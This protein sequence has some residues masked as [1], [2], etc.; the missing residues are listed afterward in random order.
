MFLFEVKRPIWS[1]LEI[2][3]FEPYFLQPVLGGHLAILRGW[4]L[5]TG[6]TVGGEWQKL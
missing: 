4:P 1:S 3:F 6:S 2:E 5:H